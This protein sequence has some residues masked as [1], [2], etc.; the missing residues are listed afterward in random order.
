MSLAAK[1]MNYPYIIH[2]PKI[3]NG[4]PLIVGTRITVRSIA[5]YYQ[6]WT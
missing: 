4:E 3:S 1:K 6:V 5:G 2:D